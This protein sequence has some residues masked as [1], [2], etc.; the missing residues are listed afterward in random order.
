MIYLNVQILNRLFLKVKYF[1]TVFS[2]Y[3]HYSGKVT[4]S[5]FRA[6]YSTSYISFL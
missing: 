2:V 3:M 4:K 6:I 5:I 1:W